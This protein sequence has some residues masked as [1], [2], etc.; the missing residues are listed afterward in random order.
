MPFIDLT[1]FSADDEVVETHS[2]DRVIL[3]LHLAFYIHNHQGL[4]ATELQNGVG[5]IRIKILR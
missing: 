2:Q 4:L 1:E 5:L 3:W